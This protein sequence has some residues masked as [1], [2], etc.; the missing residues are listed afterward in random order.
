MRKFK[1]IFV[2]ILM[3]AIFGA[4]VYVG[5]KITNMSFF[6]HGEVSY[7]SEQISNELKE[8]SDLVTLEETVTNQAVMNEE[9]MR[10]LGNRLAVPFTSKKMVV[11][12]EGHIKMGTNLAKAK[13]EVKDVYGGSKKF[14]KKKSDDED[15]EME[16]TVEINVTLKPCRITDVYIDAKSWQYKESK[17]SVF[18]KLKPEDVTELQKSELKLLKQK[19]KEGD[20][21]YRADQNAE[22]AILKMLQEA[23]PEAEITVTTQK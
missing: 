15:Q 11:E 22:A 7:D 13:I 10:I 23:H 6:N 9:N 17:E 12:Y 4:G 14:F 2:L 21:L 5:V 16:K 3:L 20:Y 19:A 1:V 18:N 8:M